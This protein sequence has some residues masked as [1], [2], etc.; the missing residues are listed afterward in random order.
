M[1]YGSEDMRHVPTASAVNVTLVSSL[2]CVSGRWKNQN[3]PKMSTMKVS[4]VIGRPVKFCKQNRIV[5]G[6]N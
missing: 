3:Y 5:C 2:R 6:G 1:R 4:S